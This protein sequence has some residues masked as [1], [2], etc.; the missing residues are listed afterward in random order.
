MKNIAIIPARSGSKGLKN[1]NIKLLNGKPLLAYTV[2]AALQSGLFDCVHVSTDSEEYADIAREFGADVPFLREA[3]LASDTSNTWDALR[4]VIKEYEELGQKF[5]TVCLLQPTSPLR[6]ATDIKN[7]YQIFEKKK[8]ESVISVCETEHSPLLCN[9]L[10]ESG[11]MKGF[12]D[13]KK[14]GRRQELSTYYRL[15]GAIYIQTV[16][17]LM[18]GGDLYGD[19]SYAYVMEKEHSVDIDDE[20]DFMFAE[21]MIKRGK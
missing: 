11:S 7:A 14:V 5:D 3:E 19:K 9:T 15:N 20:M 8:A 21:V 17:L 4:F 13:M 18:Q 16:D 2:E 10:K 12:I 1:K 6:D